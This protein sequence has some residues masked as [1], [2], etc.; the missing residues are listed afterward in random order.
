[1]AIISKKERSERMKKAWE[2]RRKNYLAS[3]AG[4]A[5][6]VERASVSLQ[7]PSKAIMSG[8]D[9]IICNEFF[10]YIDFATNHNDQGVLTSQKFQSLLNL[11]K[12]QLV[13]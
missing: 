7:I 8:V 6:K 12:K 13:S 4:N 2:T 1:M 9:G 3:T 10:E 5:V 11:V